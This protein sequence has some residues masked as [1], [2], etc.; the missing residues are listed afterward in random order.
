MHDVQKHDVCNKFTNG[1]CNLATDCLPR[2]CLRGNFFTTPL[3]SNRCTCNSS[4][5]YALNALRNEA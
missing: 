1:E 4:D 3:P 5:H 2:I